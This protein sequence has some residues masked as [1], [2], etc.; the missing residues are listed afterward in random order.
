MDFFTS[1]A[2]ASR[3]APR[4]LGRAVVLALALGAIA[5]AL[6]PAGASAQGG[7]SPETEARAEAGRIVVTAEGLVTVAPDMA[8]LTL[9]V[10]AE[11]ESAADAV[12]AM[13]ADAAALLERLAAEGIAE[14]DLQTSGLN[15]SPRWRQDSPARGVPQIEGY[16][17]ETTVQARVR[18]IDDLGGVIDAAVQSGAN[19]FRGLSFG[20]ASPS[21]ARDAAR[22]AAV[23][24]GARR[25]RLYAEAAGVEF[26]ALL[27]LEEESGQDPRPLMR[28][29]MSMADAGSVPVAEGELEITARVR[30]VFA[31]A[32]S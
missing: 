23:E 26:G 22:R 8:T 14:R 20:L 6:A 15:L 21:E 27:R 30:L 29:E 16:V 12:A 32:G 9:G 25:A 3:C 18:A 13:S 17:A 19:Q 31:I 5:P 24:E 28:A 10:V 7:P 2:A 4:A 11:A 1:S